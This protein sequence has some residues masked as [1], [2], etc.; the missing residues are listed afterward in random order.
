MTFATPHDVAEA[1]GGRLVREPP[2]WSAFRGAAI[3]TRELEPGQVFFAFRG[4]HTDGHR[5]LAEAARAG[6][7]LAVV[8]D[9]DTPDSDIGLIH[10]DNAERA[11]AAL[12]YAHRSA[13]LRP[14][15]VAVTGSA[16]KTTTTRLLGQVLERNC[17]GTCS[18]KSHNNR[19]GLSLTICRAR[20]SDDYLICEIGT[21]SPGEIDE[22]AALARPHVG[23]VTCLAR[24]HLEGFGD[25]NGV[26][27][28]A[29][30]LFPHVSDHL[31]LHDDPRLTALAPAQLDRT[32]L[33]ETRTAAL[34]VL[35]IETDWDS[36]RFRLNN[37]PFEVPLPGA[38]NALNAA[39][40]VAVARLLGL[41]DDT[42]AHA[43]AR[44]AGPELRMERFESAGVRV[45]NDSYN[46]H[47]DSMLAAI[48]TAAAL[49]AERR[50][51]VLGEMLELGPDAEQLHAEVGR[52]IADSGAFALVITVGSLARAISRETERADIESIHHETPDPAAVASLVRPGDLVL[53]KASRAVRL[54]RIADALRS[55]QPVP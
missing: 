55:P 4:E 33:G 6:A 17:T 9:A 50:V 46:A 10:V 25:L 14:R 23:V 26:A 41:S 45:L 5:Y 24:E 43:L 29:A 21:N 52:A 31:V 12:A 44:A 2:R 37:V 22:Y 11:L 15:V 36:T 7:H 13:L 48:R 49:P 51:A 32:T 30:A 1:V 27:H 19:L 8:T 38:H 18:R 16:G 42:T 3:D 39:A 53:I 35:G 54:E 40:V 20:P 47:P 28:E 34:R